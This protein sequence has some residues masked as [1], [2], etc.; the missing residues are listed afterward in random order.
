[1]DTFDFF[2]C[3]SK[4]IRHINETG[5]SSS[6]LIALTRLIHTR[7][8]VKHFICTWTLPS[9]KLEQTYMY[10]FGVFNV[11]FGSLGFLSAFY[12]TNLNRVYFVTLMKSSL[13]KINGFCC[14]LEKFNDGLGLFALWNG[15]SDVMWW[16]ILSE[17]SNGTFFVSLE[18]VFEM[19]LFIRR[20]F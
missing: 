14:N 15:T 6:V 5:L 7:I 3:T 20:N 10:S 11:I 8:W 16:N 19:E 18:A 17:L 13:R 12:A 2:L 9:L 1:M 4:T